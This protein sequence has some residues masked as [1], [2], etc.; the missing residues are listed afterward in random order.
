MPE[1]P[2]RDWIKPEV[3]EQPPYRVAAPPHRIKLNQNESCWD[4]PAEIKREISDRLAATRWNRYPELVPR[5]LQRKLG[6]FNAVD[7]DQIVVGKGSNEILQAVAT[8]VLRPNDRV[9]TLT[10]TFAV[11]RRLAEQRSAHV[12]ECVLDENFRP[13]PEV[14][15][16]ASQQ[17][18]LTILC[19]PNSP[20]GTLIPRSLI[21]RVVEESPG[22]V[23]VDEAYGDYSGVTAL[24]LLPSR[25]NLVI[26]RT[27]SKAFALAGFRI[28]YAIMNPDLAREV[29]KGL[30]PF[31]VDVPS[32][33]AAEVLLDH[34]DLVQARAGQVRRERE[35]LIER[36]NSLPGVKAWPSRA[37]F[38]LLELPGGPQRA[39]AHLLSRGILV[40]DVSGY[41]GCENVLRVTV[42]SP[43][44]NDLLYR[45][46]EGL[47]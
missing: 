16:K 20:T 29:Q 32:L 13:V 7:P 26:T 45:A 38:F 30:L 4:W 8:V 33:I 28:G 10:P 2:G 41:P 9:C 5:D 40:R 46:V 14:V 47:L 25:P 23:V 21:G 39:F 24:G 35:R 17:A 27:F 43:R 42:G 15:R 3:L 11:Y 31:N 44:E 37:N 22:I 12:V 36:L 18:R 19:N 6:A 34:Y 1:S